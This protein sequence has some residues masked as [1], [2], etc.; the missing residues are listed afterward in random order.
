VNE[1]FVRVAREQG[2]YSEELMERIATEGHIHFDEVPAE[3]QRVFVTSHDIAP[4]W[5]VRMQAA[6]QE[7]TDSAISK[8]TNFA[9]EATERRCGRSTSWPSTW[10]QGGDGVPGRFPPD[11]GPL[12][13]EDGKTEEAPGDG[14]PSWSSSSPMPGRRRTGSGWSWRHS[15]G[16]SRSRTRR[17]G[18]AGT[19]A[20]GRSSSGAAR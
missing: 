9:H 8:T 18:P 20:S 10:V 7:H 1:D 15:S 2:W 19:S 6:F 17:P 11:A 14:L 12:H 3:V 16:R 4:E 5:H 13:R